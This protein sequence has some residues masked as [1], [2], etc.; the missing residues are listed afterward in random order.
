MA[1]SLAVI[2]ALLS[3]FVSTLAELLCVGVAYLSGGQKQV[4]QLQQTQQDAVVSQEED[5]SILNDEVE[6]DEEK[7]RNVDS[8]LVLPVTMEGGSADD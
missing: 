2:I 8:A 4:Q 7:G 6:A 3:R 1:F 5:S